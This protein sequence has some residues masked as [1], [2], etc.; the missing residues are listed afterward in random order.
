MAYIYTY[1]SRMDSLVPRNMSIYRRTGT[2]VVATSFQRSVF[3]TAGNASLWTEPRALS[4]GFVPPRTS[5]AEY[6]IVKKCSKFRQRTE[7]RR[8]V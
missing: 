4:Y 3:L 7:V 1:I 2:E 5:V 6:K 8:V